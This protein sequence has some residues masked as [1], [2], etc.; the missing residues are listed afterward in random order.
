MAI[1]W[2]PFLWLFF[3]GIQSDAAGYPHFVSTLELNPG[4]DVFTALPAYKR[5][6]NWLKSHK[7]KQITLESFNCD[8][9]GKSDDV[10]PAALADI[11]TARARKVAAALGESTKIPIERFEIRA[12]GRDQA[13]PGVCIVKVLA[14][15]D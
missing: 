8:A 13:R 4:Q 9:D 10:K 2:A 6:E 11:A 14:Y 3:V 15:K 1:A 5:A 12:L 7:P